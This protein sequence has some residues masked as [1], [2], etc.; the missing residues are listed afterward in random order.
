MH[1]RALSL[2]FSLSLSLSLSV[3]HC[4]STACI[5]L[6]GKESRKGKN[7]DIHSLFHHHLHICV[8]LVFVTGGFELRWWR[9]WYAYHGSSYIREFK[10]ALGGPITW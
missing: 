10:N 3:V 6:T 7:I 8:R 5:P 2:S 1:A 4:E 9:V